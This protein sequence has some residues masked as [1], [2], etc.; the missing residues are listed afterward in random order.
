M[1]MIYT[2]AGLQILVLLSVVIF[3]ISFYIVTYRHGILKANST[4]KEHNS[5]DY[6]LILFLDFLAFQSL[7][8][9]HQSHNLLQQHSKALKVLM[10][11]HIK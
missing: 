11:A 1:N 10:E 3:L 6:V 2:Y 5:Y 7:S 9:I 4:A 8:T